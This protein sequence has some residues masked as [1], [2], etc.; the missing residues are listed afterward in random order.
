MQ[1]SPEH[2]GAPFRIK[3]CGLSTSPTMKAALETGADLVGLVF[4]PKSPRFVALENAMSLAA[5]ARGK[6]GIVALIVDA[7]PDEARALVEDLKPDWLQLHG[8]ETPGEVAAIK[9]A[10]QV[11]IMKAVGVSGV[12]DLAALAQYRS[13]CDALLLDAKPPKHAA[14]PGGH[15]QVFD[16]NILK[17]L[18]PALPV[19]VSGGLG[20]E[21]VADAITTIRSFGV[22]LAGVDVSS[23][24]ENAP[25]VKDIGKI[26]L[27]V[28]QARKAANE[29]KA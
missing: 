27:F 12:A 5:Q 2:H 14:Y 1:F 10:T 22:Q 21:N 17:K 6:A 19:M 18:D 24:V 20:P 9:A 13:V 16:W 11:K 29:V 23:G 8:S 4:H 28:E 25:G 15:G 26:R 3:I 7:S